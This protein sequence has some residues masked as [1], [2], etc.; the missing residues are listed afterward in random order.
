MTGGVRG[1]GNWGVAGIIEKA[2]LEGG[3]VLEWY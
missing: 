1:G 3:M 2:L